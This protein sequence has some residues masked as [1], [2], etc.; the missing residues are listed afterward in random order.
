MIVNNILDISQIIFADIILSG[1]NALIIGMAAA[2]LSPEYRRR[3]IFFGMAAA[4]ILRIL[5]AVVASYLLA[6]EGILFFGGLL[7]A[8]VCWRFFSELRQKSKNKDYIKTNKNLTET[9]KLSERQKMFRAL[10]T[11]TIAD[12]SMSIDNVLAVAAIARENTYLLVFGLALAIIFMAFF[13]TLI[14][15]LLEKYFWLSWLGLIFLIYLTFEMLIS[16]WSGMIVQ[17]NNFI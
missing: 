3:A 1:D 7:L 17:L 14:M 12:I 2:G 4:A 11:I 13:A 16:G 5:F 10:V 8:F 6:I 15:K 9:S